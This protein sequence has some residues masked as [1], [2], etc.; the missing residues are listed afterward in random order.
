MPSNFQNVLY[1]PKDLKV[2]F[3]NAKGPKD[4][5]AEQPYTYF[6]FK[7]ALEGFKK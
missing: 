3:T 5:A 4:R 1:E 6:D 2:W 7:A